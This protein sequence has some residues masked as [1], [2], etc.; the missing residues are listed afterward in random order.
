ARNVEERVS[1]SVRGASQSADSL[2]ARLSAW[3]AGRGGTGLLAV[4]PS[5][6]AIAPGLF[7]LAAAVFVWLRRGQLLKLLR[8]RR[9][10]KADAAVV[11]FYER[12]TEALAARGLQRR[13]DQ[14]PLEFAE[15]TGTH[16]VLVITQA[17]NRVRFGAQHLTSAEAAEV[18]RSLRSME[19]TEG[20]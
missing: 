10:A 13:A 12:M 6:L 1:S 3:W 16:E 15:T 11:E 5:P 14:T 7:F 20:E 19:G 18:E 9:G 4:L 17:Y 2:R 8:G